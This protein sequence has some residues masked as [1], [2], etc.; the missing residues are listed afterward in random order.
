MQE[1]S[2]AKFQNNLYFEETIVRALI[3]DHKFAEQMLDV[4]DVNY[5]N[6]LYLKEITGNLFSYY[7]KY[8]SFPSYKLLA[9][10]LRDEVKDGLMREQ[11]A[12]YLLKIKQEAAVG[13]IEYVKESALEFCKKRRL[14]YALD[15]SLSLL[16]ESKYENI[17]TEIQNA[18]KAGADKSIG[19]EYE[20]NLE[21]RF[22]REEYHPIPTPWDELNK[23]TKGGPGGGK[24]CVLAAGSGVGKS[25]CLVDIGAHA[26]ML[27]YNV[28]HYTLELGDIEVGQR[29]DARISEVSLDDLC[30]HKAFVQKSIDDKVKGKI[31]IK[32]Y[33]TKKASVRTLQ[34]HYNSVML[35]GIKP[36]LIVVD[37][38]DLLKS[39]SNY[40]AKRLNEEQ[41]YE[42][43]RSWSQ[44]I[45]VPIWTVTQI[46]REGMDAD[47][48]TGKHISECINKLFIS[49]LFLTMARKKDSPTP[50]VG[51][52]F[53]AKSR[54]G[55]D[56]M[57]F[58]ILI[59]T[60]ISKI[61]M[62]APNSARP[63][64]ENEEDYK[65]RLREKFMSFKN[66]SPVKTKTEDSF[67]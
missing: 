41:V 25:H 38:A 60:A 54:L 18:L 44:E 32:S 21:K 16:E 63:N 43:L 8:K 9:T 20:L 22:V 3:F 7:E 14:A 29:Y 34:N 65:A 27:G 39:S 37:Y 46:N 2:A 48:V 10:L 1:F 5:F 35:R 66:S 17:I 23:V 33:P 12:T 45:N 47:V 58:P 53:N 56:G 40:D 64:S 50:D 19:H 59:N 51:N 62:L 26:S 15:Q 52:I 49:D 30:E 13:D 55:P 42:E 4:L 67:N 6:I 61:Q 24:L 57:I 11:V 36:D 28:I 31:I